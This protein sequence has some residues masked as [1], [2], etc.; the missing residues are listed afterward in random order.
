MMFFKE[1]F[2]VLVFSKLQASAASR[3]RSD[4]AFRAQGFT[5]EEIVR[6]TQGPTVVSG[7]KASSYAVVF[8][9]SFGHF[10]WLNFVVRFRFYV[11]FDIAFLVVL[12]GMVKFWK[13]DV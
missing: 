11:F 1:S 9:Q 4:S 6:E 13:M 7:M 8:L 2:K 3:C 5:D 12:G 10:S